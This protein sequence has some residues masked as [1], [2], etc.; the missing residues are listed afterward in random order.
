MGEFTSNFNRQFGWQKQTQ[1]GRLLLSGAV[2]A[3][4]ARAVVMAVAGMRLPK[5]RHQIHLQ[6]QHG[7]AVAKPRATPTL[8]KTR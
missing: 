3:V 2:T 7:E 5:K 8:H 4:T 6:L 1:L